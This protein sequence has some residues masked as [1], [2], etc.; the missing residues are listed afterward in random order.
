METTCGSIDLLLNCLG[1]YS[2]ILFRFVCF[3]SLRLLLVGDKS[4]SIHDAFI[5][6]EKSQQLA[7]LD[8]PCAVPWVFRLTLVFLCTSLLWFGHYLQCHDRM[9][10]FI[11]QPVGS[12]FS[13]DSYTWS[14]NQIELSFY[15]NV[16]LFQWLSR[17]HSHSRSQVAIPLVTLYEQLPQA[18]GKP[19]AVLRAG[20]VCLIF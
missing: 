19:G 18:R 6:L 13:D 15:S 20:G 12:T 11:A 17:P 7:A 14:D 4:P 8:L 2:K 1:Y 5:L 16:F 9:S 10:S 3:A